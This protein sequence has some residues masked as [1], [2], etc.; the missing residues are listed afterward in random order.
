MP[1]N[2]S[3]PQALA[4]A[5]GISAAGL[6]SALNARLTTMGDD[7]YRAGIAD[8][9]ANK[10]RY[11]HDHNQEPGLASPQASA[12]FRL[13]SWPARSEKSPPTTNK[14]IIMMTTEWKSPKGL[15]PT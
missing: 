11:Q 15:Q 4:K 7:R 5:R 10:R 6:I 13:P 1:I 14:P 8:E 12:T 3:M 2:V 9:S